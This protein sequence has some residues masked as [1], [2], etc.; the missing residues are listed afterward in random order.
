MSLYC[1]AGAFGHCQRTRSRSCLGSRD[2][3]L[4]PGFGDDLGGLPT[5]VLSNCVGVLDCAPNNARRLGLDIV[6]HHEH[7]LQFSG[8]VGDPVR[9]NTALSRGTR[10][11]RRPETFEKIPPLRHAASSPSPP[12]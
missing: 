1:H 2:L 8:S 4:P 12:P 9:G 10:R 3:R 6:E 11:A 7:G 5:G